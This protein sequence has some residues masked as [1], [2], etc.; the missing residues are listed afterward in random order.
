MSASK[1]EYW[2]KQY[3]ETFTDR[4]MLEMAFDLCQEFTKLYSASPEQ[5][6]LATY[7]T[8]K[9]LKKHRV[10]TTKVFI[11]RVDKKK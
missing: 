6:D 8:M 4:E 2:N 7:M 3:K 5:A 9:L 10:D 11:E 1:N